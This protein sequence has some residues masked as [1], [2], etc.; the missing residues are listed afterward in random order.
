[1]KKVFTHENFV[2][3]LYLSILVVV[4]VMFPGE[5]A[6]N[7]FTKIVGKFDSV[8]DTVIS[9]AKIL[10]IVGIV[11]GGIKKVLGHPDSWAWLWKAGLGTFIVYSAD[12]IVTWLSES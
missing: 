3:A 4:F 5:L 1:M 9:V 2:P 6:A 12:A 8:K 10:C 7:P 11:I